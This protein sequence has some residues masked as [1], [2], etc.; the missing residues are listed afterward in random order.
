MSQHGELHLVANV[1][2]VLVLQT[3]IRI[4]DFDFRT[5]FPCQSPER[6]S[7][8]K[9]VIARLGAIEDYNDAYATLL[10]KGIR[11]LHTPEEHVRCSQLPGWYGLIQEFTPRSQWYADIPTVQQIE[12]EFR[13]PIFV[14][15]VR[16]TSRHQKS[17]SIIHDAEQYEVVVAEYRADPI[18]R[19][20]P[21][22]VREFMAL[23]NLENTESDRIPSSFEFRTFWWNGQCV[24]TGRYWW[25]G[26]RYDWNTVERQEGI[27]LAEKVARRVAVPF[28]VVDLAM[29]SDGGWI[30][31]ECNDGQESGYAGVTPL[32]LWTRIIEI[33]Q[34]NKQESGSEE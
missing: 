6:T 18:L 2:H 7:P 30:V 31:I 24:G 17:L 33:E 10:G 3:G 27:S 25:E 8:D 5:Y 23:R 22:V 12:K 20:Q 15:G 34:G 1:L 16:Q 13:W 19:W 14:K 4:Y 21:M 11:L 29:T 32:G 9:K 28:L 26:R